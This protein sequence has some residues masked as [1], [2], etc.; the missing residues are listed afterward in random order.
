VN[1]PGLAHPVRRIFCIGRNYA[2]HAR[3]M[4]AEA[5]AEPVVFMKPPQSL[6]APGPV[7]LPRGRG[8][9]HHELEL[10][11]ALDESGPAGMAL[12]L[13]L[14]LREEQAA[15]KRAGLPWERCKAFEQSAALG[16]FV[17]PPDDWQALQF[18][19][20]RHQA[21]DT[22]NMLFG[23]AQLLDWLGRHW[24]LRPGDLVYTGTPEGVGPVVPGDRFRVAGEGF[25]TSEWEFV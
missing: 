13:D 11:V 25:E 15:L 22:A 24:T 7:Q 21:A 4:G 5:P 9:V 18:E 20:R 23:V 16:P 3:E 12:G 1:W 19:G 2:A 17:A 14:T 10:V 6:V 8:A